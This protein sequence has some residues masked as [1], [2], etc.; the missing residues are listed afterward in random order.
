MAMTAMTMTTHDRQL[1]TAY[2]LRHLCQMSQKWPLENVAQT[3]E[4]YSIQRRISP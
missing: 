3:S 2:A 1:M 4:N